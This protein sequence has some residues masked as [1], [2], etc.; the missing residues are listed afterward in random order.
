MPG[1]IDTSRLKAPPEQHEIE[2]ASFF[3]KLGYDV[4]FL[5]PSNISGTHTPDIFMAGVEWEMKCPRG[6]SRRTIEQI[7]KRA[8]RQSRYLVFDLRKMQLP[9]K[10]CVSKL[11]E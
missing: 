7:F 6:K 8:V 9:T 10:E 5:R 4:V 3:A 1:S 2:T 11:E